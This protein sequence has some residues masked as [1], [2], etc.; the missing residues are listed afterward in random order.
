MSQAPADLVAPQAR[1]SGFGSWSGED[2]LEACRTILGE[3]GT[4]PNVPYL[5]YL[6]DRGPGSDEVGRA[7]ALLV[8]L[9]V[10]LQPSGW[11]LVDR[12]GRDVRRAQ[13]FL[14]SDTD[15]LAEAADGYG[16]PLRVSTLGPWTLAGTVWLPRGER[17]ARDPGAV[18]DLA[19]SL[20]D[21]LVQHLRALG[22]LV[23]GASFLVQLDEPGL[24][25][26]LAGRLPT[27]SGFGT[28][29]AIAAGVAEETLTR[30]VTR[31]REG[32]PGDLSVTV[33]VRC[34]VPEAPLPLLRRVGPDQLGVRADNLTPRAW[35]GVA[36]AVESGTRL[37][38]G[39]IDPNVTR[40]PTASEVVAQ[41]LRPW[42]D[43]GLTLADLALVDVVADRGLADHGPDR[44]RDVL[45]LARAGAA[46]LIE[47][48]QG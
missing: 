34:A 30:V 22:R 11:R 19:D 41:V 25:A 39:V 7:L 9:P 24:P 28:L 33:E 6:P 20:A 43:V 38:L 45:A 40:L 47:T 29:R 31:L 4:T 18:R 17:I 23:P 35:E 2:P 14:R 26:V 3:L 10:D 1:G 37:S 16:G 44:G 21:G 42:R 48:A 5:P 8:D 46:A 32:V 12:P 15:A 13:S 27:L 36:V